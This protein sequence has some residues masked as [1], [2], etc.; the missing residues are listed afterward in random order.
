MSE[1]EGDVGD[2]PEVVVDGAKNEAARK[3]REDRQEKLRKMM[4]DDG[5]SIYARF[6]SS[7]LTPGTDEDMPDAPIETESQPAATPVSNAETPE[8]TQGE[9]TVVENGRR[10]G[11]R[12]VMKKKKVKDEDGYLGMLCW[13]AYTSLN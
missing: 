2:M 13:R 5:R 8:S 9:A 12:R 11:K 7:P 10:R 6:K 1:D 3:A 4:E